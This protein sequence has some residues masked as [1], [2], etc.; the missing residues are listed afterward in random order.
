MVVKSLPD[1]RLPP[2]ARDWGRNVFAK[3]NALPPIFFT[4]KLIRQFWEAAWRSGVSKE[5]DQI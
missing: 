4:D 2:G 3:S 5:T 1:A